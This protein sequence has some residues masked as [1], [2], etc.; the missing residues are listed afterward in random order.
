MIR[1]VGIAFF[2]VSFLTPQIESGERGMVVSVKDWGFAA[3]YM[4]PVLLVRFLSDASGMGDFLCALLLAA[5]WLNNFSVFFRLPPAIAWVPILLPW[6]LL[7]IAASGW[8][9]LGSLWTYVPFY[10]WA[11][12]IGFIHAAAYLEPREIID[13]W[14]TE[15]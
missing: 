10:P 3:F 9:A 14:I 11:I 5:A 2:A 6:V 4:T 15:F 12:G 7:I 13:R 8:I 1:W